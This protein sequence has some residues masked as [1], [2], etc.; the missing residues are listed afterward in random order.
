MKIWRMRIACWITKITNTHSQFVIII[1][2]PLQQLL[3]LRASTLR[4]LSCFPIKLVVLGHL[5]W[6]S[7]LYNWRKSTEIPS[8]RITEM[9]LLRTIRYVDVATSTVII[10]QSVEHDLP[11]NTHPIIPAFLKYVTSLTSYRNWTVSFPYRTVACSKRFT[12]L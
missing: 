5:F 9:C 4:S 12:S 3:H 1:A 7:K 11:W 6:L 2:F 10:D 8:I